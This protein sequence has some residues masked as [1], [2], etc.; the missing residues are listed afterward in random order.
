MPSGL[1][2]VRFRLELP[3]LERWAVERVR[4]VC[5]PTES[6]TVPIPVL[7]GNMPFSS[8]QARNLVQDR[9]SL[10]YEIA[11]AGRG[12]ARARASYVLFPEEFSG[13]IAVTLGGKN[14]TMTEVQ[15]GRRIGSCHPSPVATP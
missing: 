12:T 6:G 14:M 13:R 11:C 8:C 2:E 15:K 5:V 4:R 9:Q 3:H 10:T 1:F 7:S